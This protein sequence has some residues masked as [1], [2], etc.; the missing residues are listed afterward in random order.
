MMRSSLVTT[1]SATRRRV[2][3]GRHSAASSNCTI[4]IFT[5]SGTRCGRWSGLWRL[6]PSRRVRPTPSNVRHTGSC[7]RT[8]EAG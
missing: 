8:H 7:Y 1:R 6:P 3:A 5:L 2:C 4:S